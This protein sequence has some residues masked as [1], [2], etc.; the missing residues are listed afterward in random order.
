MSYVLLNRTFIKDPLR[1]YDRFQNM[2]HLNNTD[3]FTLQNKKNSHCNICF[4][5]IYI[6][7]FIKYE[8]LIKYG[9]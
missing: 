1:E 4:T 7:G 2:F 3:G 5:R 9:E 8:I 6:C